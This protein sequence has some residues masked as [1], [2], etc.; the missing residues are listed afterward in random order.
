MVLFKEDAVKKYPLN[1]PVFLLLWSISFMRAWGR[2]LVLVR[3]T[4]GY[5]KNNCYLL[6]DPDSRQA[7]LVDVCGP[8]DSL[9]GRIR[10]DGLKL[11]YVFITHGH[12]DHVYGL[13]EIKGNH[14]S[15]KLVMGTEEYKDMLEYYRNWEQ[16][17]T[18]EQVAGIKGRPDLLEMLNPENAKWGA[19]DIYPKD[20]Q[21]FKLGKKKITAIPSPGHARGSVC[22]AAGRYLFTGDELQYRRVGYTDRTAKTPWE[23]QVRSIRRLYTL[24]PDSTVI[25][26]G[27]GPFSDIGSEKKENKNIRQDGENR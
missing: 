24:F 5:F 12:F 20:G 8:L 11:K 10:T 4:A 22:Y 15:V 26:P 6:Y 19:P 3:Q 27:H 25:C 18:P 21:V 13:R 2:D 7:A 17:M 9:Q 1:L 14:P 16:K 23:N